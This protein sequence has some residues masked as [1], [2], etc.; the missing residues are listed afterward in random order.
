MATG[1][2]GAAWTRNEGDSW[3]LLPGVSN[4]WAV[5]FASRDAG[6]LVGGEGRILKID[7]SPAR[8]NENRDNNNDNRGNNN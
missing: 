5:G 2:S 3:T 4:S 7:F 6:W 8:Q 1:P